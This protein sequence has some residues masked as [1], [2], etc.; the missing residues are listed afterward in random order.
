M[1]RFIVVLIIISLFLSFSGCTGKK[2]G[3]IVF[4]ANGED[5]VRQGFIDRDGWHLSFDKVLLNLAGPVAYNSGKSLEAVLPGTFTVDLAD[6]DDKAPS[7]IVGRLEKAAP[8]NYQSLKFR[9]KRISEGAFAGSSIVLIGMAE[10]G[11]NTVPFDIRFDEELLFDGR[12][13]YVGDEIKG[14]LPEGGRTDVEMTF[15]FDHIFGDAGAPE[16]DHINTGSVGF[17]F[18]HQFV[19]DGSV[20]VTQ[21]DMKG[22]QDYEKL[23]RSIW[24]LGHLGEGHC[25]V[26]EQTTDL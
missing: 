3:T 12:E 10:R 1:N 15:H 25:D 18:F 4:R 8:G 14:L 19:R 7:A 17:G 23:V 2:T 22:A 21:S 13:G 5:F 24:T 6:G 9:L 26:S 16:D 20:A 11:G